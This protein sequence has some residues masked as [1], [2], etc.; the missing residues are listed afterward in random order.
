MQETLLALM[1]ALPNYHY[2]PDKK[3]HF[4]NYLVGVLAHKAMD[5]LKH[6]MHQSDVRERLKAEP[7]YCAEAD[8]T[9]EEIR[10]SLRVAAM[11]AAIEQLMCDETINPTTREV[12]R[13][14]A[15]MHEKP[16]AVATQFGVSRNNVDQIKKRMIGKLSEMV[17]RM[18]EFV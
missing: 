1:K 11:E 9:Q 4:R 5:I 8:C 18:E 10:H 2:T 13:H 16:D 14:V 7:H 15:L 12:F 3:L 17:R 6:E